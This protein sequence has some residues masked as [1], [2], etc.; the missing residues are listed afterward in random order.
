VTSDSQNRG[1]Q[2]TLEIDRDKAG[3]LGVAVGDLRTAL[4]NAYGDRQIGSIYAASNTYQVILSAA[5]SDRQFEDDVSR[6]SVRSTTGKLVP[7]SAFSTINAR[8][9]RPR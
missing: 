1:L 7:L 8:W 6:L 5:D 3:V 4:Y 2:A 9:G